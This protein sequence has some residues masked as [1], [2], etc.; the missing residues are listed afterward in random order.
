MYKDQPE[1]QQDF[2]GELSG[3]D[4]AVGALRAELRKLGVAENTIVW[5]TSDNGGIT[6][7]SQDPSGKGKMTIGARTVAAL[8]WPARIKQPIRT[9]L[10]CGHWDLYPTLLEIVG[11]TMPNQP[12]LDGMSL[13]GLFDGS[14]KERSRPMGF[15]LR[16]K[17]N[18][19]K[20]AGEKAAEQKEQKE[21]K[22][23]SE[24]DFVADTQGVWIDGKFKLIVTPAAE[25]AGGAS[26]EPQVALYDI[27]A[28]PAHKDN[29]AASNPETVQKMCAALDDWRRSVR[30]SFDGKDYR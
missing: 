8:E 7:M 29:L 9:S 2:L 26:A 30:A 17:R 23:L 11:V 3:V 24:I 1:K 19:V 15:M 4:A 20:P 25:R 18:G 10:P 13:T 6:P 27:F 28:D 5:F 12:A 22:G 16:Q 21:Q 14:L